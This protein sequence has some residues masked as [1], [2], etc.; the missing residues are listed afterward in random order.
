MLNFYI[1]KIIL[2]NGDIRYRSILT[3]SGQA[4]KTKTFRRKVDSRS[5][6]NRA[7]LEFQESEAK[8]IMLCTV[9]FGQLTDEY[10][11]CWTGKDHDRARLVL[12]WA[13]HFEKILLSDIT[14]ELIREKLKLKKIIENKVIQAI[15]SGFKRY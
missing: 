2:K 14:P 1:R 15:F 12:W 11:H 10:M 5:W 13:N 9:T 4:I 8:G 3:R 7:V 6:G